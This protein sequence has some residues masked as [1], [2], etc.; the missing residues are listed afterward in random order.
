[1]IEAPLN[2]GAELLRGGVPMDGLHRFLLPVCTLSSSSSPS[3][4]N[5]VTRHGIAVHLFIGKRRLVTQIFV[6]PSRLLASSHPL[7]LPILANAQNLS[8][9]PSKVIQLC[10]LRL[11]RSIA[12]PSCLGPF[13]ERCAAGMLK[14]SHEC[15]NSVHTTAA[16]YR[17][18]ILVPSL[19]DEYRISQAGLCWRSAMP[20][21]EGTIQPGGHLR[22]TRAA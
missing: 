5:L 18:R 6:T 13:R 15:L 17:Q 12:L 11:V 1:M 9:F 19:R 14:G 3:Y 2:L 8:I 10:D 21:S 7:Q 22:A 4:N 20:L 16:R